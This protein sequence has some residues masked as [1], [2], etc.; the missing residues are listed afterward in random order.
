MP[1]HQPSAISHDMIT[2]FVHRNGETEQVDE[3]RSRLARIRP[4]ASCVWVDL[5]APSIPESLILSDTFAFPPAVGRGRDVGACSI[6][7]VGG[8]RRLPLRRSC[9]ASISRGGRAPFRDARRRLL[10][11]P[12]LSRHRAR[13][14]L[15]SIADLRDHVPRGMRRSS[16][17]ARSRCSTASSTRWSIT[18]GPEMDKLEDRLDELEKRDLRDRRIRRWSGRS[19]TRSARS[20]A[21]AGSSRRSAT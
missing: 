13:R 9:T 7:K 8:L 11:R 20:P 6:P 2:I 21:C 16:A 18:I 15:P 3:H 14:R 10:P 12:E 19:S 5:A 1:S 17:K 4:P